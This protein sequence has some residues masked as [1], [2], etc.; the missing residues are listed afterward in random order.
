MIN[1]DENI[2]HMYIHTYKY[3]YIYVYTYIYIFLI[4]AK[5]HETRAKD[6]KKGIELQNSVLL[7]GLHVTE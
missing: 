7:K 5:A 3:T 4:S 6:L 2:V 1:R